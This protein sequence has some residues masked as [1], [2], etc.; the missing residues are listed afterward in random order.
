[1]TNYYENLDAILSVYRMNY[2][3][4]RA[5]GDFIEASQI[6]YDRN[7]AHPPEAFLKDMP[8]FVIHTKSLKTVLNAQQKAKNYC[9]YWN[10]L[11]E[12]AM[13]Q[14]REANQEAYNRI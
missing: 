11:L 8:K 7:N 14:F 6:L 5:R 13:A 10:P 3:Q 12:Q 9:D 4:A 1:M 2:L